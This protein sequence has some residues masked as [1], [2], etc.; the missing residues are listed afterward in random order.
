MADNYKYTLTTFHQ[1]YM[2]TNNIIYNLKEN[3]VFVL[4]LDLYL[5]N[6][7]DGSLIKAI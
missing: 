2:I 5:K 3:N 4:Q 6:A 7:Y 1:K